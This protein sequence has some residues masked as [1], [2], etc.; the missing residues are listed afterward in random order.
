M[1]IQRRHEYHSSP[2]LRAASNSQT[3]SAIVLIIVFNL[4]VLKS[5]SLT[6]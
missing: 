3:Y 5:F 6:F 4:Y 1:Y 2:S